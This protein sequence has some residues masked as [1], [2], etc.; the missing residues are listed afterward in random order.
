MG[1]RVGALVK[2]RGVVIRPQKKK[3]PQKPRKK[4]TRKISRE[5]KRLK[6]KNIKEHNTIFMHEVTS[7]STCTRALLPQQLIGGTKL[8][9]LL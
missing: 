7:T 2:S 4:K 3:A 5:R 1:C 9:L 6:H 8:I